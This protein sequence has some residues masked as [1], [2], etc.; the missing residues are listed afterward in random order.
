MD[1]DR[2]CVWSSDGADDYEVDNFVVDL[3]EELIDGSSGDDAKAIRRTLKS[4]RT[5]ARAAGV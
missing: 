5:F 4:G 1:S 3:P 2:E